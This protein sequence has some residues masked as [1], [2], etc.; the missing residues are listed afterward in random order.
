MLEALFFLVSKIGGW[1]F[2]HYVL[3]MRTAEIWLCLHG[4]VVPPL[5]VS[6]EWVLLNLETCPV[7][8]NQSLALVAPF[9]FLP[10][11]SPKTNSQI[12][13]NDDVEKVDSL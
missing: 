2:T 3:P 10:V 7:M 12:P 1:A 6:W 11:T 8:I 5:K 9:L 4:P 13:K